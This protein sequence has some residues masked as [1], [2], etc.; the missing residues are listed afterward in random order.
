MSG[1]AAVTVRTGQG[2]QH[3]L[4]PLAPRAEHYRAIYAVES[5]AVGQASIAEIRLALAIRT[6][7]IGICCINRLRRGVD[8]ESAA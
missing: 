8:G 2:Q 3:P 7:R 6:L 1:D 5:Q 4:V